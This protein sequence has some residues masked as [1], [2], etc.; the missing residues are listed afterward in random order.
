VLAELP[1]IQG[2][3]YGAGPGPGRPLEVFQHGH[4]ALYSHGSP[5]LL[6]ASPLPARLLQEGAAVKL[7][8]TR[9]LALRCASGPGVLAYLWMM[10][11]E[12]LGTIP[13]CSAIKGAIKKGPEGPVGIAPTACSEAVVLF[14]GTNPVPRCRPPHRERAARARPYRPGRLRSR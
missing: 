4:V 1:R 6:A 5:P 3:G 2:V 10:L 12:S 14:S 9:Y 13:C 11:G 7:P 8:A